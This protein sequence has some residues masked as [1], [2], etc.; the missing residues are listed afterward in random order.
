MVDN[1][2]TIANRLS[3]DQKVD[4]ISFQRTRLVSILPGPAL[5]LLGISQADKA[6]VNSLSS[7]D[8]LLG[9]YSGLV[10][11]S[12]LTGSFMSDAYILFGWYSPPGS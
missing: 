5:Q 12:R 11:K 9:Y 8:L 6:R 3:D 10:T 4:Y 2:V 1:T 7:A